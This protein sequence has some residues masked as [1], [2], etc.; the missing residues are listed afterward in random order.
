MRGRDVGLECVSLVWKR[1]VATFKYV[2]R[3]V[4][5]DQWLSYSLRSPVRIGKTHEWAT[6]CMDAL[7]GLRNAYESLTPRYSIT[8]TLLSNLALCLCILGMPK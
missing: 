4:N 1:K 2:A 7:P 5:S 8:N 6:A 3:E